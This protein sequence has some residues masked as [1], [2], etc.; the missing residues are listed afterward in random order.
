MMDAYQL[1]ARLKRSELFGREFLSVL[2]VV[3][4]NLI[5]FSFI[6]WNEARNAIRVGVESPTFNYCI[7]VLPLCFFLV[8]HRRGEI[9]GRVFVPDLGG[10]SACFGLS[11]SLW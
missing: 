2:A 4:V 10:A 8:W 5:V 3:S 7:L 6:F 9:R 1:M 11:L